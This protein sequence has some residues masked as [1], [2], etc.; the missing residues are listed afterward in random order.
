VAG[1]AERP[2][3]LAGRWADC[4]ESIYKFFRKNCFG[5]HNCNDPNLF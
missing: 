3:G 2:G 1:W 5:G 4:A